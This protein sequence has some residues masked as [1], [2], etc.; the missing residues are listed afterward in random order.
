MKLLGKMFYINVD[1]M[2]LLLIE[3]FI[4]IEIIIY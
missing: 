2:L 4:L 3:Q 1:P